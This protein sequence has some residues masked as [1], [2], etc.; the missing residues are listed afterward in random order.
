MKRPA[1]GQNIRVKGEY[2]DGKVIPLLPHEYKI[3]MFIGLRHDWRDTM[4]EFWAVVEDE[5]SSVWL[6]EPS[7]CDEIPDTSD[8]SHERGALREALRRALLFIEADEVNTA[9]VGERLMTTAEYQ[10]STA[11][12]WIGYGEQR[13]QRDEVKALIHAALGQEAES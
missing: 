7:L 6:A 4:K 12:W 9:E 8:A 3:A 11:D 2:K 13:I 5:F 10:Y 1:F